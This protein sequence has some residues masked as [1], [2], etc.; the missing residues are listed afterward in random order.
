MP[1]YR[2]HIKRAEKEERKLQE[3]VRKDEA[4]RLLRAKPAKPLN[5]EG[6]T[7]ELQPK[8]RPVSLP[9]GGSMYAPVEL[10]IEPAQDAP[11]RLTIRRASSVP[12]DKES[13]VPADD[14]V[15][16]L[17]RRPAIRRVT[18]YSRIVQNFYELTDKAITQLSEFEELGVKEIAAIAQLAKTLPLLERAEQS[19]KKRFGVKDIK[20]LSTE[21]LKRLVGHM[22]KQLYSA[23]QEEETRQA[24]GVREDSGEPL[25]ESLEDMDSLDD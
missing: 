20:E 10:S 1:P 25:D 12:P 14:I 11:H 4:T 16:P 13:G 23:K 5:V 3:R 17:S 8:S 22:D 2:Q 18:E 19:R 15:Q 6:F 21:E 7:E 9:N 24:D